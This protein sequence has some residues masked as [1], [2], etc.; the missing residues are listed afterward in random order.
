MARAVCS[1]GLHPALGLFHRHELNPM[2]LVDD[3]ME[4]FRPLVDFRV[5][6][7]LDTARASGQ[8][9]TTHAEAEACLTPTAKRALAN[10]LDHAVVMPYGKSPAALAMQRLASSLAHVY[11]KEKTEL[12]LPLAANVYTANRL[13]NSPILPDNSTPFDD[14]NE[15]EDFEL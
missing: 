3:L 9:F 5:L 12:L 8:D 14:E 6:C 2:R 11:L 4:I 10:V 15:E 1:A 7:L 13:L